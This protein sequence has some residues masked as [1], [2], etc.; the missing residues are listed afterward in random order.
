MRLLVLG[1]TG[2]LGRH[3]VERAVLG[4]WHVTTF[5]RGLTGADH[6]AAEALRGD[7][8]AV[9]G[10]AAL[11]SGRW[12]AVIDTSGHVPASVAR[13]ARLVA[14]RAG[15][16]LYVSSLAALPWP[17]EPAS[18]ELEP[19]E[20]PLGAGMED[21]G[22]GTLKAGCER[23][24]RAAF[25]D[26]ALVV[27]PGIITGPH[28]D[29]GPVRGWLLRAARGGRVL[30]GGDPGDPVQLL[31]C[32]DVASWLLA[33]A[34]EGR[35]GSLNAAGPVGCSTRGGL[36]DACMAVTGAGAEP[37]WADDRF[38]TA[39]GVRPWLDLPLWT[40]HD[41]PGFD[42]LWTVDAGAA[43]AAGLSCRP[44]GETVEDTW[45]ELRD[46]AGGEAEAGSLPAARESALIDDWLARRVSAP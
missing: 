15:T 23:A 35:T 40:P 19:R 41:T 32:R 44:L 31:D 24:V 3:I 38:L 5:N 13:S 18:D 20:C 2:F 22:Y 29:A 11:A 37:V 45:A 12:D 26:R 8:E 30:M 36:M 21:T 1:G 6:P 9:D 39:A 42:H 4:G 14:D 46:T 33:C 10:L 34:R 17:A 28:D 43:Y 7:R 25:G 27:R 16:Y